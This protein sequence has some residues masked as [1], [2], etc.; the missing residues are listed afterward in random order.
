MKEL[1]R[2]RIIGRRG[3]ITHGITGASGTG[4]GRPHDY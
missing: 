4:A 1:N 3:R 2:D